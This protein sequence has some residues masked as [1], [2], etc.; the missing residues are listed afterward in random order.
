[1][2]KEQFLPGSNNTVMVHLLNLRR[3]IETNPSS[4]RIIRTVW[5]KGY[6]INE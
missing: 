3:K 1:V 6:Q 5:G 2:W 4:P